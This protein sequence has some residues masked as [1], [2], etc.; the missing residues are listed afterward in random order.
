MVDPHAS[1]VDERKGARAAAV[2]AALVGLGVTFS[3][4]AACSRSDRPE[5]RKMVPGVPNGS[6]AARSSGEP[7]D[8]GVEAGGSCQDGQKL[9]CHV[10]I[11][12]TGTVLTCLQGERTCAGGQW[13][14]CVGTFTSTRISPAEGSLSDAL[15]PGKV[16]M[17][18][19]SDAGP[20]Q[21]NPCDPSCQVYNEAP[22]GGLAPPLGISGYYYDA[23]LASVL[24][25]TPPGFVDKGLKT[26]C[27]TTMDCQFD[28][29]CV[30]TGTDGITCAN[31]AARC[32]IPWKTPQYDT[33]CAKPDLTTGL[34]CN[35]NGVPQVP[36]CNRGSATAPKDVAIFIFPGNSTQFPTC[37]PD[38]NPYVCYTPAPIP[39][40]K[41]INVVGC[42]GLSGNGTKTVMVNPPKNPP[43][44]TANPKWTDECTCMDNWGVWSGSTT[45]CVQ[46]PIY[47]NV[48][49]TITQTYQGICPPNTRVQWGFLTWDATTPLDS[50]IVFQVRAAD[51]SSGLVSATLVPVGTAKASPDT[52]KCALAGPSPCP[53]SLYT[54]L[55]GMPA[56]NYP[57]LDLVMTFN[58]SSDKSKVATLN[59]WQVTYSC[60][61]ME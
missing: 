24:A 37:V 27:S 7:S 52:Q 51:T 49:Q 28:F 26:P 17:F 8:A 58:P 12:D 25:S 31:G 9:E 32:C 1:S 30:P 50:N 42:P 36:V 5:P 46:E 34:A 19:L 18:S 13:G 48:P 44:G 39:P 59:N 10:T 40:G 41:C 23:T 14:P 35:L 15:D 2:V 60:P 57:S 38:N 55:G 45:A 53:Y 29:H 33:T 20:C 21:N 54:I 4:A 6:S 22:D 43:S 56:G 61:P 11:G 16:H 47:D 3:T